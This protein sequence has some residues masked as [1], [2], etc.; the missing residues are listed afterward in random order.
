MLELKSPESSV[1]IVAIPE[2]II[3]MTNMPLVI[4]LQS[5]WAFKS[6]NIEDSCRPSHRTQEQASTILT[7]SVDSQLAS[8]TKQSV[9]DSTGVP[10][11]SFKFLNL[12][13]VLNVS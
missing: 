9:T 5:F 7:L 2:D 11:S 8:T 12:R 3:L 4:I 13:H 6:S 1:Q 10:E